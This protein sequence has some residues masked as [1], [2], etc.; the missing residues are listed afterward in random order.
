MAEERYFIDR[1]SFTVYTVFK[2]LPNEMLDN[3]I[4]TGA[5]AKRALFV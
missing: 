2:E 4:D 3:S 1:L 5:S